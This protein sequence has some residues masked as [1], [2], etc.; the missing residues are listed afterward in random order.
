[1]KQ[2]T[3]NVAVGGMPAAID[4][5][6]D[7]LVFV[8]GSKG[9]QA[10]MFFGALGALI[11]G[12]A[13][14]RGLTKRRAQL[15]ALQ[16]SSASQAAS[17]EGCQVLAPSDIR[18][19]EVKKGLLGAGRRLTIERA[20]GRKLSLVYNSKKQPTSQVD[21]L[22]RPVVGERLRVLPGA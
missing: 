6:D 4:V 3:L 7:G 16:A 21:A 2:G 12:A 8:P 20:T 1:M 15:D 19:I 11:G 13:A 22:L 18:S 9:A 5:Y 17:I 14:R 10:G